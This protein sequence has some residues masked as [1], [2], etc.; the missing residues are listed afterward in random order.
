MEPMRV[1]FW[2]RDSLGRK[3]NVADF[4]VGYNSQAHEEGNTFTMQVNIQSSRKVEGEPRGVGSDHRR[5][6]TGS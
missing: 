4:Y 6:E 1:E 5:G 2:D 3:Q